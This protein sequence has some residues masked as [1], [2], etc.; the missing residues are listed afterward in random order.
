MNADKFEGQIDEEFLGEARDTL[1]TFSVTLSNMRSGVGDKGEALA[2]LA[3]ECARLHQLAHWANH[4]LIDLAVRRLESYVEGITDVTPSALGDIDVFLMVL[5]SILEGEIDGRADEGEFVRSLPVPRPMDMSD[6]DHLDIEIL[7]VEPQRASARIFEREL[8]A[9]GYRVTTLTKSY[10]ALELAVRTRP[11]M[12]ISSFMLDAL[13]GID[14][15]RAL[16]AIERTQSIPFALLTSFEAG[17]AALK[18]LPESAGIIRK[19]SNFGQDLAD[20]FERFHIT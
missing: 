5:E 14:F 18:G 11:D 6:L 8:R 10:E 7:L 20:A 12:V 17:H 16:A 2:R 4:P 1:T 3:R 15:C 9:A 19:D 13:S